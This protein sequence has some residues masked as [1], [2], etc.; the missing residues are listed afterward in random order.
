MAA[1][2]LLLVGAAAPR[3]AEAGDGAAE[4]KIAAALGTLG[5][6]AVSTATALA[7]A[8]EPAVTGGFA[9][10]T[11]YNLALAVT[12]LAGVTLIGALVWVSDKPAA[13][14]RAAGKKL[15]YAAIPP[16][17]ATRHRRR[18]IGGGA[19]L[20][21][22]TRNVIARCNSSGD[23]YPF[24]PPATSTHALL[25]APTSLWHR[26]LDDCSHYIWTF[27]LRLK[28]DTFSTIA[29]FFAHVKTQFGTTIKSVQCDNGRE[30]DNSPART[31]FLSHG[32]AFRMSCPYTSQQNGRAERSLRTLNNILRSLLFQACLPPVYWVEAL[33]TATLLV[34]RIPTKTLSS[35]TPYFHLYSTQ[36]TYDHLRVF[37][38]ACYPNMSSTAPHKLAP[39]SSLCVFLGYSSEHKGY[40]CLELGSNRIITS[41]HVVFDE[42]F[43]PFADM[44]TS[45]MA[46]SALDIFLDDNELT[47]QPPRAKFV[48]AGTSS[49]AR[50][51]VEPSTP[52]P[53]PSSIG[54]RSPAT[55]AGPEAGPHGGSPAGA[56]TSQPGAIS[57]AR[58]AAPSA[59]TSTTRAVTSAPRAATSG[60]TPSLS[61]LAGTAAPPPRAE[62]AASSTA[63][64]GRTLAT[65]PVSIAPV[66]NAHSMR[67]RGKAGMAQPVDRLN[68][69]AAPLSPVPRSVR[70]ALSDPNWRAAMQAEFDA[71]LA[72]DTWSLGHDGGAEHDPPKRPA[73]AAGFAGVGHPQCGPDLHHS[74]EEDNHERK[75]V[76][77]CV[78]LEELAM[79]SWLVNKCTYSHGESDEAHSI[80]LLP[81]GAE[82]LFA[83]VLGFVRC[84]NLKIVAV[85]LHRRLQV[86]SIDLQH[87]SSQL[88]NCVTQLKA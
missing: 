53:A 82:L 75:V 66:D 19:A 37:G 61:P 52:P 42:S 10:N 45:P 2:N 39:R 55:L 15:L 73:A 35:S 14:R 40:R 86:G 74:G 43:F 78:A 77:D 32:V 68:L 24:Y 51:A 71:L 4:S 16:L 88:T 36:P 85:G 63:A 6:A 41:R 13:R 18:S 28:S 9:A 81:H 26:R 72:N 47:A 58:T 50:G 38:C 22:E 79:I 34:N 21:L 8:F 33:H 30:F 80:E 48:H 25:A 87:R 49:A 54:P 3:E 57:P 65:R 5:L 64:T 67:T 12:F 29:N 62:V 60:T 7:A 84:A 46:S 1:N 17:V 11:Y 20:D 31:F 44:S 69:H 27:P 83:G 23:L 70:E 59:A 76:G 56:A